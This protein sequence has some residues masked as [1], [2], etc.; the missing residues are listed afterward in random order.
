M[1]KSF[2]YNPKLGQMILARHQ[3]GDFGL[4]LSLIRSF[5]W[6]S[7]FPPEL[8]F[9]PGKPLTYHYYFD[10]F[11]G[12]LERSGVRIDIALNGI[13]ALAFTMLLYFIYK[14]PQVLFGKSKFLGIISVTL[15]ILPSN[16]TFVDFFRD[17]TISFRL[18]NDIW[19]LPD[20]I[21]KGPFDGSI[22]SIFF[23]LNVFLNQRHL[24]AALAISL[25][26]LYFFLAALI[27]KENRTD[28][29]LIICGLLL[30]ISS[31]IH[32]LIFLSNLTIFIVLFVFFKR[33]RWIAPF[34]LPAVFLSLPHFLV[35]LLGNVGIVSHSFINPGF[36]TERPIEIKNFLEYWVQNFGIA[37]L[38]VPLGFLLSKPNQ[39]RL[40]LVFF[41]LFIS[42]NIFQFSFR[43]D[44][45]HSL[46]NYFVITANF[47]ITY[48][49]FLLW[50]K[51]IL[52]KIV[53][54]ILIVPLM[55]SGFL[56]LMVVKNDYHVRLQDA[57]GNA[58]MLWIKEQTHKNAVFLAYQQILDPITL[59]GRR[60]YYGA[61]YYVSVMGYDYSE[62]RLLTKMFF[63]AKT[64]ETLQEM[65]RERIDYIVL[66]VRPIAD[67]VYSYTVNKEFFIKNLQIVYS[68]S[69]VTV[70]KL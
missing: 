63:E 22:I 1:N 31:G 66:P 10:L 5:S 44:H 18:L 23:T 19:R 49:L 40:L 26:L 6:G 21:H 13:S 15:F 52:H 24:V 28:K 32:T 61:T 53:V 59:S 20:Y 33:Y 37:M 54:L 65:R 2:A 4:H 3:M 56:D 42:A 48:A 39:R 11:V 46:I 35:I 45:N 58:F 25:G 50:K 69:E 43:I 14:I 27:K 67:F 30:G 29:Q 62:R 9:F 36:L 12:I 51:T 7:N 47:Y 34:F 60:N 17:R 55:L 64:T 8:P 70:Y 41:L 16:L 38:L 57:P 68:D